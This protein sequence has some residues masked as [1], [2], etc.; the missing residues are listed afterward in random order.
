[1][2]H[3]ILSTIKTIRYSEEITPLGDLP[4]FYEI[5]ELSEFL[6]PLT[7]NVDSLIEMMGVSP[8]HQYFV[9][10]ENEIMLLTDDEMMML[11]SECGHDIL[12]AIDALLTVAERAQVLDKVYN[13]KGEN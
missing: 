13:Q 3:A 11:V 10:V 1:M 4:V 8:K 12:K 9:S 7:M 5:D 2:R 6:E